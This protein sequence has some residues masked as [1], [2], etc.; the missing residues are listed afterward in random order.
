MS[1]RIEQIYINK[2]YSHVTCNMH[3]IRY[4]S[5]HG[6]CFIPCYSYQQHT[7]S[8]SPPLTNTYEPNSR[9]T[10]HG[11]TLS[12]FVIQHTSSVSVDGLLLTVRL[13]YNKCDGPFAMKKYDLFTKICQVT[14]KKAG[15]CRKINLSRNSHQNT[16]ETTHFL[17]ENHQMSNILKLCTVDH[18]KQPCD[19]QPLNID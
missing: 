3:D 14:W 2:S 7:N 16:Q 17:F 19:A 15:N 8:S 13:G 5:L 18:F 11:Y 12:T 6:I 4:V 1:R 9:S 10:L